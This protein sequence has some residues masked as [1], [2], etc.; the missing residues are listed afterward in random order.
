MKKVFLALVLGLLA[1]LPAGAQPYEVTDITNLT[2]AIKAT[3]Q[4]VTL[5][6]ASSSVTIFVASGSSNIYVN[7]RGGAATTSHFFIPAGAA[8][9]YNAPAHDASTKNVVSSFT[10]I[11]DGAVGTYSVF[12]H[13]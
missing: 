4:T 3:S 2:D 5:A 6:A 7:F 8:F 9:T 11:G 1:C 13:P 12:A 10:Y